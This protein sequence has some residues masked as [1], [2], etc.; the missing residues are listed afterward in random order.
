MTDTAPQSGEDDALLAAELAFG[1]LDEPERMAAEARADREPAFAATVARWRDWAFEFYGDADQA[2]PAAVWAAIAARLPAND[3]GA[4]DRG[5]QRQL[6]AWRW[7]TAL[8]SAAALVLGVLA[9][10]P[11]PVPSQSVPSATASHTRQQPPPITI[12]GHPLVAMLRSAG[13]ARAV[14]VS[15]DPDRHGLTTT[16]TALVLGAHDAELWVIPPDGRPRSLG[17]VSRDPRWRAVPGTVVA[18]LA[19]G[20]TLAISVEP[21][22]GSPTGQPTGKVIL[23]A[24]LSAT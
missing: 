10:R 5:A 4:G 12:A 14:A 24:P 21:R 16:P 20:A 19:A 13:G 3:G 22:G 18:V 9:L 11:Q 6:S 8:A 1:L 15:V 17:V 2:P 23:T 7:A